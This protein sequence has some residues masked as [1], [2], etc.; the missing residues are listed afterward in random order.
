MAGVGWGN[1]VAE[2]GVKREVEDMKEVGRINTYRQLGH[3]G[4]ELLGAQEAGVSEEFELGADGVAGAIGG[5]GF[6]AHCVR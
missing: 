3:N 4:L 6:D 5:C 1:G 2:K